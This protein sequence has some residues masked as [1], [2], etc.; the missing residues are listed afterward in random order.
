MTA[1]NT[2][3]GPKRPDCAGLAA[4]HQPLVEFH[5]P[6]PRPLG[7]SPPAPAGFVAIERSGPGR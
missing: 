6:T 1:I 7:V 5:P 2:I 3:V 4:S